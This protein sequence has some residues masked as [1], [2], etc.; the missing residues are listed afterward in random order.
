V[1][2]TSATGGYLVPSSPPPAEDDGLEDQIKLMIQG[3][4][5]FDPNFV[6]PRWQP[7]PPKQPP[8]NANW[9]AFGVTRQDPDTYASIV[10]DGT[11]DGTDTAIR[12]ETIEIL[13]SFY[14]P[15][16]QGY[17][18]MLRD[19]L[20][21]PQNRE[22]LYANGMALYDAMEIIAAPDLTNT[23]WI[24]RYDLTVRLRRRV[25]RT[26]PVLNLLSAEGTIETQNAT[27]TNSQD[28]ETPQES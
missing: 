24:R 25:E 7:T 3:I 20:M 18:A 2:N 28:W 4:T 19:G 8:A 1:T 13:A 16:G 23:Q 27:N 5:G 14:G 17:A 11:G 22:A 15:A 12:H 9:C 26:Y 6:R 10:H 21:I